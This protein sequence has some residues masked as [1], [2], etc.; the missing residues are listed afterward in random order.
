MIM[1]ATLTEILD[2]REAR[3]KRQ[4]ALLAAHKKPLLC[5]TMNIP[6]P[7]KLDR[8]VAIGF[9]VGCRLLRDALRGCRVL[10]SQESYL[11]TGCEAYYV[12]DM[13][14]R[15]L[16]QLAIDLE[17]TDMIGRLF[18]MDVLDTD[19]RKLTR[20]ELGFA[21]RQCLLCE[22]EAALC[23]RSRA[24]SLEQ[25]QDRTGF[26]LYVAAR[27]YLC[28]WIAAQAYLALHQEVS[29]TP[30]PGL[31]D[32]QNRGAHKDMD[33]RHFFASANALRPYF[34]R[35]A[36]TGFLTREAPATQVFQKLRPIGLEAE[37]AMGKATHGV[38]THK[39][40]IFT[41]GILCAVAGRLSPQD[42]QPE[43]LLAECAQ[44]TQGLVAAD[45]AGV[46]EETAKTTGERLYA[47][48]GVTGVRGQAEA[49][50]PAVKEVGLPILQQALDRGCS[51]ND[52]G[53]IT[54]M[55]LLA[56]ADDTNLIHRS[57]RHFQQLLQARLQD[58]LK[59]NPF[60]T[61]QQLEQIDQEFIRRNLSPGG[62][63]DLLALTYFLHF[64]TQ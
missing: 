12:V 50:Y 8:D 19:G 52:A 3:V 37:E 26:L 27:E 64:L 34:Y 43:Q 21:R 24:H 57:S 61:V 39:G 29:A 63:A 25:L 35:F 55:H 38:N 49:G 62:S 51:V 33:I 1:E 32:R 54:L 31:V 58:Y 6:G 53:C 15:Q 42:W 7:V 48:Y 17:E 46:T 22:K 23:A 20:E 41:L 60:P 11:H 40:A 28:E 13:P 2:A 36:Q 10:H 4:N 9:F 47:R 18:D 59:Q 16:K 44:L 45:F 5:F 30:K 14:A 56:A